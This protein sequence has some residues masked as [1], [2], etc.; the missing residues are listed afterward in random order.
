MTPIRATTA[1]VAATRKVDRHPKKE[2]TTLPIGM[3]IT[4]ARV[5]PPETMASAEPR[6]SGGTSEAAATLA[7]G[8]D[9]APASP[10]K[11]RRTSRV[12]KLGATEQARCSR[13]P[14]TRPRI[15]T[16]LRSNRPRSQAATGPRAAEVRT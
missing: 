5:S 2:P 16:N 1:R 10:A 8:A 13:R 6:R 4:K 3:P 14:V 9:I 15:T 7:A 12:W 11:A